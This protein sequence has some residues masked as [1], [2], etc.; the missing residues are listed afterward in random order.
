MVTAFSATYSTPN[1][2]DRPCHIEIAD[3]TDLGMSLVVVDADSGE[4]FSVEDLPVHEE[5]RLRYET[6]L[7]IEADI[8]DIALIH[9]E[10]HA[11]FA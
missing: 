2:D 11:L 1:E 6:E 10:H 7:A 4:A 3:D 9:A 5:N 8:L